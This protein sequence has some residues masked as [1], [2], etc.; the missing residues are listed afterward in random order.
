MRDRGVRQ[1]RFYVLRHTTMPAVLVETGFV[2]GAEDAARFRDPAAVN[3]IAD[4]IAR[5]IL[6]YLGR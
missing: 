3:R 1:A 4:G 6:D 5:G 2:T